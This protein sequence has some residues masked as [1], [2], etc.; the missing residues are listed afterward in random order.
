MGVNL[1]WQLVQNSPWLLLHTRL[2]EDCPL[3]LAARLALALLA[4]WARTAAAPSEAT[5][6]LDYR[7]PMPD[8]AVWRWVRMH[9]RGLTCLPP[10]WHKAVERARII[11]EDPTLS[12]LESELDGSLV[13]FCPSLH[14]CITSKSPGVDAKLYYYLGLPLSELQQVQSWQSLRPS[15]AFKPSP[16]TALRGKLIRQLQ[17]SPSATS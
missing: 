7:G 11:S 9:M 13:L 8:K 16:T 1:G 15:P 14:A 5:G 10:S 17:S 3:A 12:G 4:L 6:V 2:E